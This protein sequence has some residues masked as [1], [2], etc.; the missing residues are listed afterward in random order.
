[1]A[2]VKAVPGPAPISRREVFQIV[3]D[4]LLN[5]NPVLYGDRVKITDK[6]VTGSNTAVFGKVQFAEQD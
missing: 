1:M 2:K 4:A 6:A 3:T 5:L